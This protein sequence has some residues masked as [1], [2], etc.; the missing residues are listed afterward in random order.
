MAQRRQRR[1]QAVVSRPVLTSAQ[2][3]AVAEGCRAA[4]ELRIRRQA[5]EWR[6]SRVAEGDTQGEEGGAV[7]LDGSHAPLGAIERRERDLHERTEAR[8]AAGNRCI[9]ESE[10]QQV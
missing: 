9:R 5:D 7:V 8:L 2:S 4:H 1:T 3:R 6:E 10:A